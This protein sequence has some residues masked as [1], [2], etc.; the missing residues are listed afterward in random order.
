MARILI[1]DDDRHMRSACSRVLSKAGWIVRTAET[2]DEGLEA[3]LSC[4][5]KADIVLLDDLMPGLSGME[6]LDRIRSEKPDLPVIIMSGSA[7][8]ESA[9]EIIKKG[10]RACLAKPF[11]PDQLRDVIKRVA[12]KPE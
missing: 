1:I 10:A 6:V 12:N 3:A 2:G 5:E 7:T 4:E 8:E 11:T 9:S